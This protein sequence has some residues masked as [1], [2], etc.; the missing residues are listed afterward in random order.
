MSQRDP[1]HGGA[2]AD[3]ELLQKLFDRLTESAHG[4]ARLE[5][6]LAG[7]A[8]TVREALE[9][10]DNHETELYRGR[11][12]RVGMIHRLSSLEEGQAE[13]TSN[14]ALRWQFIATIVAGLF[15]LVAAAI[16][17]LK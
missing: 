14:A 11:D 10:L 15:S 16:A 3:T 17:I 1:P 4:A 6:M 8:D 9:K 5:Q 2:A 7:L 12:G 13:R